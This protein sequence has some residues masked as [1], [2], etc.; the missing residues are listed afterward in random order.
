MG[1]ADAVVGGADAASQAPSPVGGEAAAGADEAG[2]GE[3]GA[4]EAGE[5]EAGEGEAAAA[6]MRAGAMG[7]SGTNETGGLTPLDTSPPQT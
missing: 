5:G 3:A 6:D 2:E 4:D 1:G 7:A